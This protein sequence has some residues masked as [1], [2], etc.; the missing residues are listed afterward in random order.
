MLSADRRSMTKLKELRIRGGYTQREMAKEAGICERQYIRIENGER[1]TNV[2]T[3][4]RIARFLKTTVED[5][6]ADILP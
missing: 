4:I 6:F 3:A 1:L 2:V 5:C